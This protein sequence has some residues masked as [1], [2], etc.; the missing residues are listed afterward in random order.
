MNKKK[1]YL[2][3]WSVHRLLFTGALGIEAMPGLA[4]I[5]GFDGVELEDIFFKQRDR[6]SIRRLRRALQ[7]SRQDVLIAVSNDFTVRG[8]RHFRKQIL[9]AKRFL[10]IAAQLGAPVV[11]VLMGSRFSRVSSLSRVQEALEETLESAKA[12]KLPLAIENHDR[13]SRNPQRL[14]KIV[15]RLGPPDAG[16][17]LDTGNFP[18]SGRYEAI[19]RCTPLALMLHAKGYGFRANGEEATMSYRVIGDILKRA[20]YEGPIVIEYD[21]PG[22]QLL[23]SIRLKALVQKHC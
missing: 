14:V 9:H 22:D 5:G 18:A 10:D 3:T 15:E 7:R 1:V 11:R 23:G 8:S 17:C 6:R 16:I 13:L 19:A 20:R 4:A 2:S 12:L 21:G